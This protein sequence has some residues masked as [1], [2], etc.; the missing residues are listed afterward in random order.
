[1]ERAQFHLVSA[2]LNFFSSSLTKRQNKLECL[3][4]ASIFCLV[5]NKE[6]YLGATTLSIMTFSITTISIEGLYVIH[7]I[8]TLCY[9]HC[10][11]FFIVK[12][13]V[14]MLNVVMLSVVAPILR[15]P[16]YG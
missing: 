1:M 11:N 4:L 6:A 13:S 5:Y 2:S 3:F 14:V 8:T 15:S 12:L 10:L 7:S 16:L 9:A